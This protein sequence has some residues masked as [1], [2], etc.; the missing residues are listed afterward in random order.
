MKKLWSLIFLVCVLVVSSYARIAPPEAMLVDKFGD[1]C[2]EDEMARLDN[3]AIAVQNNPDAQAYIVFYGGRRH[4]FP[5]CQRGQQRL[6]RHG[7]AEA[8]VARLRKYL[9]LR[10]GLDS[11]RIVVVNGG[12]RQQWEAELWIVPKDSASP[13]PTPTI[14]A[15]KIKFRKGKIKKSD[16]ECGI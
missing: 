4:S 3:F 14:N 8:R 10:R 9:V 7:E 16:Y 11:N 1:V 2:C 6:P 5:S 15:Q 12:Y 13:T